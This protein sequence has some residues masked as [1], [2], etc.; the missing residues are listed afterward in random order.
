MFRKISFVIIAIILS[1]ISSFSLS[2][3]SI[4]T[5]SIGNSMHII[6][7]DATLDSLIS[8][9]KS[10]Q[11]VTS[12]MRDSMA[13]DTIPAL[14]DYKKIRN[15][16]RKMLA[17]KPIF[18]F[19]PCFTSNHRLVLPLITRVEIK[20]LDFKNNILKKTLFNGKKPF[21]YWVYESAI[22]ERINER[23]VIAEIQTK[24][25]QY[26]FSNNPS[27]VAYH[28]HDLP[29]T[30]DVKSR[31]IEYDYKENIKLFTDEEL[32]ARAQRKLVVE[33]I[34]LDKWS[35]KANAYLQFSE[36]FVSKNWHQGGSS[37]LAILGT[38]T[39]KFNYDNKK[40][41]QWENSGEWRAGFHS[42]E[43]DT[44]RI[45]NTN[46]D[47]F[48]IYSKLGIKAGGNFFYSA[49]LDFSTPLFP[50]Y[51][52][53]NS[54]TLKADFMTPVRTNFSVGMDYKY[55]KL[56]SVMVSPISFKYIYLNNKKIDSK[57]F[58]VQPGKHTLSEIGS[59]VKVQGNYAPTKEMTFESRLTF[60]TNYKK[61]EV[62]WELKGNFQINRFLSTRIMLNPR[63]DNTVIETGSNK[64]KPQF[65]QLLT[66]GLAYRLLN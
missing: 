16:V 57:L 37:N 31:L 21:N 34:K 59:S 52:A 4:N 47:V 19:D 36:N 56:L 5:D 14:I 10:I 44:T 28:Q 38:L 12:I 51:K 43:E 58:G 8:K 7:L 25:F 62:D 3:N 48:K 63:Y 50:T 64:A 41:I 22:T 65:K 29:T 40:N 30:E 17:G 9:P 39:A 27:L 35:R 11:E 42:V 1:V 20:K 66:F 15:E 26:I 2:A 32:T 54:K 33:K 60:Y 53:V 45:F 49:S 23:E 55:K 13:I 18:D 46:D 6:D 24:A 61:V